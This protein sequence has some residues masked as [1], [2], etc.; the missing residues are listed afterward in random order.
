DANEGSDGNDRHYGAKGDDDM[1][2]GAGNDTLVWNNGD[3]SDSIDGGAGNDATEVNGNPTLGDA[4]TLAPNAGRIEFQRANL[5]PFTLE[6]ST[7]RFQ[8]NGLGG[9]DSVSASP[10]VG[11][12]TLLS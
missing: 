10:G 8:V 12:L 3:G 2:G 9:N 1:S 7:E 11:A 5:V 4:F 6:A